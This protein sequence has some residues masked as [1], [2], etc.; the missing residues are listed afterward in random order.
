MNFSLRF[1]TIILGLVVDLQSAIVLSEEITIPQPD[2]AGNYTTAQSVNWEMWQVVD[3]D[4]SGLN[5]RV[6]QDFE[7]MWRKHHLYEGVPSDM[8]ISRWQV[9]RIFPPG[10]VLF[11]DLAPAGNAI[12]TD[13]YG[14]PWMKISIDSEDELSICL[15]RAHKKYIKPVNTS[16]GSGAVPIYCRRSWGA[17]N[18]QPG[19]SQD[20]IT[21]LVRCPDKTNYC[22]K[23]AIAQL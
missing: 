17:L 12:T 10:T 1:T 3:P 22:R 15:I 14:Q 9:K 21:A 7:R 6:S 13:N 4:S 23:S 5:C 19:F 20:A 2:S 18:R 16:F 11:A 8:N